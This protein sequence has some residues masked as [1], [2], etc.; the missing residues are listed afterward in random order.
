MDT[1]STV[2]LNNNVDSPVLF[3]KNETNSPFQTYNPVKEKYETYVNTGRMGNLENSKTYPQFELFQENHKG[4]ERNFNDSLY[5][6]M[7]SSVP[8]RVFFSEKN[9]NNIQQKI[10][11]SVFN[12]SQGKIK[13]GRQSDSEL[14]IVMRSIFLQHGQNLNSKIQEQIAQLNKLVLNYCVENVLIGA[15]GHVNYI[16]DLNKTQYVMDR[17]Q[18]VN[19]KGVN[20]LEYNRTGM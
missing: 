18:S 3:S 4:P 19:I 6:I 13:I 20:S 10:I 2:E 15:I 8:A 12:E 14:K 11:N 9:I 1:Y 16:R 5:G 7:E 17:P